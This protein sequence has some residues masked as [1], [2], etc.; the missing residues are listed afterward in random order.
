MTASVDEGQ[1]DVGPGLDGGGQDGGEPAEWKADQAKRWKTR[2]RAGRSADREAMR[3]A[4]R[5]WSALSRAQAIKA[6]L[7]RN[8]I[9]YRL[10]TGQ[11]RQPVREV[12]VVAGTP[13]C[14]EQKV[15]IACLAG[16]AGTTASHLTAAALFGLGKFPAVPQVTIAP[17]A[18]G[19]FQGAD[20]F[21][22]RFGPG[23]TCLRRKI[24]C[25]SPTRTVVDCAAAGLLDGEALWDLV[26]SAL[27]KK[28]MQPSRVVRASGRAW[29]S[30][31]SSRRLGLERLERA[32]DVWRSGAPAGSPPEARLQRKL[33]EWGFPRAERQVEVFDEAGKFVARADVGIRE[34]KVLF[35]YNSDEHHGPRFWLADDARQGRLE[36][37]GWTVV[38]VDRFDLRPSST[39]LKEELEKLS[40]LRSGGIIP[41]ERTGELPRT[42]RSSSAA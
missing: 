20:T 29:A 6:G 38:V 12:Y 1:D 21:R 5:Q 23:E 36:E 37:L 11:W 7:T 4:A 31:R 13:D 18:S 35:E 9:A 30:A 39:R 15:M 41:P 42:L 3:V 27:C 17:T 19:R 33:I 24:R 26:D 28:L 16:P 25:T 8:Q 40:L 14:W 34:L 22:G 32:L 10:Q 2:R